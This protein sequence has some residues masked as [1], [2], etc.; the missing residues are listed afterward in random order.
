MLVIPKLE[1]LGGGFARAGAAGALASDD[2]LA[3]TRAWVAEGFS[4]L[5]VVDR[6]ALAGRGSNMALVET[7]GRDTG[8]EVDL[9]AGSESTERIE[10][11][12]EAGASRVVLGP[13]A[14]AEEEWLHATAEAFPGTLLVETHV[15][16]RRVVTRGWVRTLA[17]DL[18]D[19]VE[20]L[21]DVPVAGLLVTAP[22]GSSLELA[23]LEDVV[24]ACS[25]P[26]LVEDA[27]PTM[28]A[29]R[30]FEHR[31]LGGV[32]VPGAAL[33][34]ALDSRSVASEFGR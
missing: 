7:I 29:L 9:S 32:V 21:V 28:S 2:P 12:F 10:A 23:L 19:L 22:A 34:T 11:C 6:D 20:N 13:R 30:A 3:V 27:H 5:Q 15:R 17:V 31:G 18:L 14:L 26:V 25:F 8:V 33:A 4:R 16:E 1:L 24:D